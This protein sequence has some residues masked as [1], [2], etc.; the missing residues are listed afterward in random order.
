MH[1]I[2]NPG[3]SVVFENS[4]QK[5][6]LSGYHNRTALNTVRENQWMMNSRN[7]IELSSLKVVSWC[8]NV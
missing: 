3:E 7:V 1:Y 2:H 8:K 5:L 6:V 4:G